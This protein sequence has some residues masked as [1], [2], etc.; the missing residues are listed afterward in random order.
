MGKK[1]KEYQNAASLYEEYSK[2]N[3]GKKGYGNTLEMAQKG[4]NSTALGLQSQVQTAARNSGMSRSAA[5]MMGQNAMSSAYNNAF[6]NQQQQAGQQLGNQLNAQGNLMNS[7]QAEG[8]NEF[9]RGWG[10]VANTVGAVGEVAKTAAKIMSD[11]RLK[12]YYDITNEWKT[13]SD[14]ELKEPVGIDKPLGNKIKQAGETLKKRR[15]ELKN[16][17]MPI[18]DEELKKLATSSWDRLTPRQLK[19]VMTLNPNDLDNTV[20]RDYIFSDGTIEKFTD[21]EM[22]LL[23]GKKYT[24]DKLVKSFNKELEEFYNTPKGKLVNVGRGI[25]TGIQHLLGSQYTE[26]H[27]KYYTDEKTGEIGRNYS[28]SE[29]IGG[30]IGM[31]GNTG[32]EIAGM[33]AGAKAANSQ[34]YKNVL[35]AHKLDSLK[36][37]IGDEVKNQMLKSGNLGKKQYDTVEKI[38][39]DVNAIF[40]NGNLN[41]GISEENLKVLRE[42]MPQ[43]VKEYSKLAVEERA[44]QL[45]DVNAKREVKKID[46]YVKGTLLPEL[47]KKDGISKKEWDKIKN[48]GNE[49]YGTKKIKEN[50][51][52]KIVPNTLEDVYLKRAYKQFSDMGRKDQVKVVGN[53]FDEAFDSKT[54]G[55]ETL[56]LFYKVA[57]KLKDSPQKTEAL[58]RLKAAANE[59]INLSIH[60]VV[61]KYENIGSD[62]ISNQ[63]KLLSDF[64][65]DLS[66]IKDPL[67]G[68]HVAQVKELSNKVLNDKE[69]LKK[70]PDLKNFLTDNDIIG[71]HDFGKL[72]TPIWALDLNDRTIYITLPNDKEHTLQDRIDKHEGLSQDFLEK[73]KFFSVP[74]KNIPG[75]SEE[76][77][78]ARSLGK[79]GQNE[80]ESKVNWYYENTDA[81]SSKVRPYSGG[82]GYDLT[83]ELVGKMYSP[84][85]ASNER[86]N[87]DKDYKEALNRV[88]DAS[89]NGKLRVDD[90]QW[91][92]QINRDINILRELNAYELV[93]EI[94]NAAIERGFNDPQQIT[95]NIAGAVYSDKFKKEED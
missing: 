43:I 44:S 24:N 20:K 87:F 30:G 94:Q 72:E 65:Q 51:I 54:M 5:A 47:V 61:K 42:I 19:A 4:A 86:L 7:H 37:L 28:R 39:K 40:G 53:T 18:G 66:Y 80:T 92:K 23:E 27:G 34:A 69:F 91:S 3:T 31:V 46:N 70:H 41:K 77:S 63:I 22:Y 52:E 26:P 29:Q 78:I 95:K 85:G 10:A 67:T 93:N 17:D 90:P 6:A 14:E 13:V 48:I 62:E 88:I 21:R 84:K 45:Y 38:A 59:R 60:N 64:V 76:F 56:E 58:K 75:A 33:S 55:Q 36:E 12:S 2:E 35:N 68:R 71:L 83:K 50:G 25:S 1:N 57:E 73:I 49:S 32:I 74:I 16:E 8:N 82:N 89:S 79:H 15:D 11:E 9:N 81:A